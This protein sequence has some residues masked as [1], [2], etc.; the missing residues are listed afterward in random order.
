MARRRACL[1]TEIGWE[2]AATIVAHHSCRAVRILVVVDARG[3]SG[4][5]APFTRR[6]RCARQ[7]SKAVPQQEDEPEE[8]ARRRRRLDELAQPLQNESQ[9]SVHNPLRLRVSGVREPRRRR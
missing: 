5:G 9:P 4:V 1:W 3:A 2:M 7:F 8:G 6:D